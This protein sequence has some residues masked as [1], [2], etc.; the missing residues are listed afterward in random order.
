MHRE[1]AKSRTI[2]NAPDTCTGDLHKHLDPQHTHPTSKTW[3]ASSFQSEN[4]LEAVQFRVWRRLEMLQ[5]QSS[6]SSVC[7]ELRQSLGATVALQCV[8]GPS[9]K[10]LGGGWGG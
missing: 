4:Q 5:A 1:T 10:N 8:T 9:W 7:A 6:V 2:R 3:H